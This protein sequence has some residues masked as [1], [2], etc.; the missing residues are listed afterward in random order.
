MPRGHLFKIWKICRN[1]GPLKQKQAYSAQHSTKLV[2]VL[3]LE[4]L[5]KRS[6][7]EQGF[8]PIVF[9]VLNYQLLDIRGTVTIDSTWALHYRVRYLRALG[10]TLGNPQEP[11]QV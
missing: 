6:R 1:L 4:G 7:S 3:S 11:V 10:G 9:A 5:I 2:H 8:L